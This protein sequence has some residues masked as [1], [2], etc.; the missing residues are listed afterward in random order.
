MGNTLLVILIVYT[1]SAVISYHGFVWSSKHD[2]QEDKD[3]A[4]FINQFFDI[5]IAFFIPVFN[6]IVALLTLCS[7]ATDIILK[8][9]ILMNSTIEYKGFKGSIKYSDEDGVFYGKVSGIGDLISYEGESI[10]ETE[11]AFAE[12]VDE[13]LMNN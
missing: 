11:K 4:D 7:F 10:E 9:Y 1:V 6:S 13:Y 12:A 2:D 5:R 3:K 8:I